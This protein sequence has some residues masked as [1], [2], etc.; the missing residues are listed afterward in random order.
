MIKL[1]VKALDQ[2]QVDELQEI[3]DRYRT[4][5][6]H[7]ERSDAA[8]AEWDSISRSNALWMAVKTCLVDAGDGVGSCHYCERSKS[9]EIEHIRPKNH[10]PNEAFDFANYVFSCG[11]CNRLKGDRWAVCEPGLDKPTHLR[12]TKKGVAP[13]E[14]PLGEN[15]FL[16]LRTED[17]LDFYYLDIDT[18]K[19]V[20]RPDIKGVALMKATY[21]RELLDLNSERSRKSNS[22]KE[23]DALLRA[24]RNHARNL[25][26]L[27]EDYSRKV[28]KGAS[29]SELKALT[30]ELTET[31]FRMVW[32]QM[33]KQT[34][35]A[36][37][38]NDQIRQ[39]KDLLDKHPELRAL[40]P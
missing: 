36:V 26:R 8:K 38:V 9:G 23:K 7:K 18:G 21:T 20:D 2:N 24:R 30:N 14:P 1:D 27:V 3:A 29:P 16:D 10:Y 37:V 34:T 31:P 11:D 40:K 13:T 25:I 17:P 39:L 19:V 4:K 28:G 12:K 15:L 22:D 32:Y 33:V 6:T 5:L 35:L